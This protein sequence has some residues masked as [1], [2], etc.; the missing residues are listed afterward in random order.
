MFRFDVQILRGV[1]VLAVMLAHFGSLLPGGFLGVDIFF[2]ISGFVIT[3]S[4]IN[5]KNKT[6]SN[7]ELLRQFW[8]RRFWRLFPALSLVLSVT[9]V[10]AFA[11]LPASEFRHQ[12]EM[13]VWSFFFL[14]NVG[15]EVVALGDYFD[16]GAQ[17]N[18]LLHL[19]S[20]GVEEQFYLFFPFAMIGLLAIMG[21]RTGRTRAIFLAS[22][23]SIISFI[24]ASINEISAQFLLVAGGGNSSLLSYL[25]GYYSPFTRAWQF[26]VGIVAAMLTIQ[27]PE[28]QSRA[29]RTLLWILGA[30]LLASSMLLTPESE[31]L[32]GPIT[33]W[34]MAAMF[35]F[36]RFPLPARLGQS[37]LLRPLM[38]LGD[39]SYSIYLWHWP[40][41]QGLGLFAEPSIS[42]ILASFAITLTLALGTNKWLE[43]PIVEWSKQRSLAQRGPLPIRRPK[44]RFALSFLM[45]FPLA[46]GGGVMLIESG[47]RSIF[48]VPKKMSVQRI[49]ADLNCL[50]TVCNDQT[51]DVL[52]VGDSH[53][54]ALA[55]PLNELLSQNDIVMKGAIQEGCFHLP[56]LRVRSVREECR[57]TPNDVRTL[58]ETTRPKVVIFM[59]YTAGRFTTI[60]SGKEGDLGVFYGEPGADLTEDSAPVAYETALLESVSLVEELDADTILVEATPDYKLRPEDREENGG[61]ASMLMTLLKIGDVQTEGHYVTLEDYEARHGPFVSAD[62]EASAMSERVH[63]INSWSVLCRPTDCSQI[64]ILGQ[65]NFSDTDHL[66]ELGATLLSRSIA[67]AAL[68]I[69]LRDK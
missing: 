36:L 16:P 69:F 9:L 54:G 31:L 3:L 66:T 49:P 5:L 59:G 29:P 21:T 10:T 40:V 56:S 13:S 2:A 6:L 43:R 27:H 44:S 47:L 62:R 25:L 4:F 48:P 63:T 39:K 15:A 7:G 17:S 65:R 28:H 30:G 33:L 68:A 24:L 37:R 41:W 53:A 38:W 12:W 19:W 46:F 32:P 34:P 51:I 1:A 64:S 8:F 14:G 58:I 26:G 50:I 20:L 35:I 52:L 23:F 42:V 45:V 60:N 61:E 11:L 57:R 18:W 67:D 55:E 22:I